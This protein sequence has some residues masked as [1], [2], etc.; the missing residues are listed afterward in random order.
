MFRLTR[1]A[2]TFMSFIMRIVQILFSCS[3]LTLMALED[4]FYGYSAF[5][6]L[7]FVMGFLMS[8]GVIMAV[9]DG[10]S[11]RLGSPRRQPGIQ[12][13]IFIADWLVMIWCFC[14]NL[15]TIPH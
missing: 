13:L 2:G 12:M 7:L 14:Y 8:W 3:S 11:V 4:E 5:R 9:V 1:P 6:Y 15:P 10:Y